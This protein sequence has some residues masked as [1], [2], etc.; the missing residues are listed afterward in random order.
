MKLVFSDIVQRKS[1]LLKLQSADCYVDCL[2]YDISKTLY[3][4]WCLISPFDILYPLTPVLLTG[5]F[6]FCIV[7]L[8]HGDRDQFSSIAGS[9]DNEAF[10]LIRI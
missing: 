7:R 4:T 2:Q 10:P 9:G 1:N 8:Y 3:C 6:K 5:A